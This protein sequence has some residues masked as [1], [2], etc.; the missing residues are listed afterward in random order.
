[1]I[2][3]KRI[4][5]WQIGAIVFTLLVG[6]LL[7]FLFEISGENLIIA[8]F[9]AIN[10]STWEHLKLVFFPTIRFAIIEYFFLKNT[11]NNYI[12]AKTITIIFE[13]LFIII[14]FYTY[15]GIIGQSYL[16]IDIILFILAVILGEKISKKIMNFM[17]FT[18]KNFNFMYVYNIYILYS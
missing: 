1:M 2:L 6:T 9:S 15:T 17:D 7:H 13:M 11:A 3:L 4:K 5:Y 18:N 14:L 12:L 16:V 10:E 8:S